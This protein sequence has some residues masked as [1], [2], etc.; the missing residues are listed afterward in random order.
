LLKKKESD[1]CWNFNPNS[2]Y[3]LMIQLIT[4]IFL[5]FKHYLINSLL[6]DIKGARFCDELYSLSIIIEYCLIIV[7]HEL[8]LPH[9][10]GKNDRYFVLRMLFAF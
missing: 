8:I 5:N 6:T 2:T 4:I 9:I 1:T 3:S 7:N 10:S